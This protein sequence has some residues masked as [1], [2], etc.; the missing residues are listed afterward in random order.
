MDKL[1]LS[2]DGAEKKWGQ[3]GNLE[4]EWI[5]EEARK[6]SSEVVRES[7]EEFEERVRELL[8]ETAEEQ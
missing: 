3:R 4:Q 7:R 5:E 1:N 6:I 2:W 8:R